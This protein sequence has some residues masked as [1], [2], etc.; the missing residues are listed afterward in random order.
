MTKFSLRIYDAKGDL[1]DTLPDF[2]LEHAN[3]AA[4]WYV[5]HERVPKV[6]IV[7]TSDGEV[8]RTVTRAAVT[9]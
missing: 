4:D 5:N 7:R 6:E 2:T 8:V 9:R 3:E 1:E